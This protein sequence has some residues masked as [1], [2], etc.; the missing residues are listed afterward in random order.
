MLLTCYHHLHSKVE[1]EVR[2]VDQITDANFKLDIFE[3]TLNTNEQTKE[4][5]T[6]TLLIFKCYQVNHKE[7]KCAFQ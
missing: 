2:C 1:S 6:K 7:I 4:L 5:V 3:Q